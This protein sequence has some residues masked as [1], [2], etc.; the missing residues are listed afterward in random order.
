MLVNEIGYTD[1]INKRIQE[2]IANIQD[3]IISEDFFQPGEDKDFIK[4]FI[5]RQI[6]NELKKRITYLEA[7]NFDKKGAF[8]YKLLI[9]VLKRDGKEYKLDL[10]T[11][12]TDEKGNTKEYNGTLY[13]VIISNNAG[14]TVYNTNSSISDSNLK[15]KLNFYFEQG[16]YTQ[17]DSYYPLEFEIDYS[18]SSD[19]IDSIIKK[20]K[21][22]KQ[23]TT[24]VEKGESVKKEKETNLTPESFKEYKNLMDFIPGGERSTSILIDKIKDIDNFILINKERI[25]EKEKRNVESKKS[26]IQKRI[27]QILSSSEKAIEKLQKK[28]RYVKGG[29][30]NHDTFGIGTIQ[31]VEKFSDGVYNIIV[32]FPGFGIK[33]IRAEIK[34]KP[35]AEVASG[36]SES[37]LKLIRN[38]IAQE[39]GL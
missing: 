10:I 5:K 3:L 18:I 34:Q 2:R 8:I 16:Y 11:K 9:P 36:L 14:I 23:F 6:Q 17:I 1:H 22:I 37:I 29:K 32:D 35:E 4:K 30:F 33:K 24:F 19:K 7:I 12:S 38:I 13:I 21:Q 31:K 15:K 25:N 28:S 27:D 20:N 39:Q 26:F